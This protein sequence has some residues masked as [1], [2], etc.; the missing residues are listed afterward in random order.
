MFP[1]SIYSQESNS[2]PYTLTHKSELKK[3]PL[4]FKVKAADI[5]SVNA[6]RDFNDA[7]IAYV[8]K[9]FVDFKNIN[10][11][12]IDTLHDKVL[13][14]LLIEQSQP[15]SSGVEF[16]SLILKQGSKL[17][18]YYITDIESFTIGKADEIDFEKNQEN[19]ASKNR[20]TERYATSDYFK[21]HPDE[22]EKL[23]RITNPY[24]GGSLGLGLSESILIELEVLKD[25]KIKD[26]VVI[27]RVLIGQRSTNMDR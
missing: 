11:W 6:K 3:E 13:Y 2:L 24:K 5:D 10:E 27:S 8:G 14:R 15:F 16:D 25:S 18:I 12:T 22:Y 17:S 19:I 9:E 7:Y 21:N 23:T 26:T 20:M 1:A 4:R